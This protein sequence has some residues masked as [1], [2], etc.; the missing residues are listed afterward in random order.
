[1]LGGVNVTAR[2]KPPDVAEDSLP[3][4][5]PSWHM[6]WLVHVLLVLLLPLQSGWM[7]TQSQQV[8]A[9]AARTAGKVPPRVKQHPQHQVAASQQ[10]HRARVERRARHRP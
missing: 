4:E 3:E 5:L 8:Q 2:I 1:M 7:K 6:I 9:A 10:S